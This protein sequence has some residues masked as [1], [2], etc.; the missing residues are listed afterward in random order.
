[1][2]KNYYFMLICS[3]FRIYYYFEYVLWNIIKDRKFIKFLRYYIYKKYYVVW[4]V[5]YLNKFIVIFFVLKWF[6]RISWF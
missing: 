5:E 1:M 6:K 4:R 2:I 3:Y